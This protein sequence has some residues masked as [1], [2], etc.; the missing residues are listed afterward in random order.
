MLDQYE[1]IA[2][3]TVAA[4]VLTAS[5]LVMV[6][7]RKRSSAEPTAILRQA[8]A[9]AGRARKMRKVDPALIAQRVVAEIRSTS[10]NEFPI[11]PQD[12]DD[13]IERWCRRHEVE[14]PCVGVVR[15]IVATLPGVKRNRPWLNLR[16]QTHQYVRQRQLV[17]KVENDR[18]T[19]YWIDD[20]PDISPAV[21][22]E[23]NDRPTRGRT[24]RPSDRTRVGQGKDVR[25]EPSRSDAAP[26]DP[27]RI[28]A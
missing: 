3:G 2:A 7:I 12:L 14:M 25:P 18:P 13:I 27:K 23:A 1:L 10:V 8:V 15:E 11:L 16:K 19:L 20:L 21:R 24:D 9:D 5:L 22:T 26:A 6:A 17:H 28:A 4:L